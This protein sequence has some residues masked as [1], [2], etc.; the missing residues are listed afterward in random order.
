MAGMDAADPQKVPSLKLAGG[1]RIPA[2]GMGT[3]GSDRYGAEEV[4]SAVAGALRRGYRLFDCAS[5]YGNEARIGKV[6]DDAFKEGWVKREELFITSKVWNDMHGRG[7]VLLSLAKSLRDLRLDYVDAYFVHWPFPNYHAPQASGDSRNPDSVPFSADAFMATWAR[8]ERIYRMGLAKHLGMS[9]M[10]I[11]KLEAVLG[12]CQVKPDLIEMER[13]PSF[14]QQA[15]FDYCG[16]HSITVI[17]YCPIGSPNR[18]DRDKSPEDV[19]DTEL[20]EVAA[21]A[22]AHGIHPALVCLKWAVQRGSVPIPFSVH[23]KNYAANLRC[24][25][26]DPLTQAEMDAMARADKNCRLVKGQVFL[27]P[28]AKGWEDLWDPEGKIAD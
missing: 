14:Q 2:I 20:P 7:D 6:F 9:N 11:P 28:G 21:V 15:L 27:W 13:H 3:F 22:R 1:G 25:T 24:V 12:R 26:E 10:T 8:M 5:V 4:S 19:A 17:G 23:E 16:N 18:P